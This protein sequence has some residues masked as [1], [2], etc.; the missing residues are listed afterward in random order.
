MF[1]FGKFMFLPSVLWFLKSSLDNLFVGRL[2]GTT[3][4]GLY[5]VAVSIVN[6]APDQ[7]GGRI[8]RVMYP[9]YSKLQGDREGLKKS[10][11][12][13]LRYISLIAFPSALGIFLLGGDFIRLTYADKWLGTIPVLRVM[14]LVSIS[15]LLIL[16]SD[17]VLMAMGKPEIS[18]RSVLV[19]VLLF[20]LLAA[21]A[22]KLFGLPGVGAVVTATSFCAMS[23]QYFWLMKQLSLR[24]R[25]IGESL[26]P[27]LVASSVMVIAVIILKWGISAMAFTR[28]LFIPEFIFAVVIYLL[29]LYLSKRL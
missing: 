6:F 12:N 24:A 16:A 25:E 7:F 18:F 8:Y 22:A 9:A 14:A 28:Y 21:P 29:A 2:L 1:H 17:S 19:Q 3:M 5:A 26:Y 10:F 20:F 23:L 15:N 11:L 27:S 13:V 4:L